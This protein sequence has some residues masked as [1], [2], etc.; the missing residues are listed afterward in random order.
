VDL[1]RTANSLKPGRMLKKGP[2]VEKSLKR[3]DDF[4]IPH[5]LQGRVLI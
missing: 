3:T 4:V 5:R 2:L 1:K